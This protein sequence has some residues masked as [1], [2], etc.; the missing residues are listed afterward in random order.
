MDGA[1]EDRAAARRWA[2]L[3]LLAL[4]LLGLGMAL[5]G[6][7]GEA[8]GA[9]AALGTLAGAVGGFL[10]AG[11]VLRRAAVRLHR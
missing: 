8:S 3:G 6:A 7:L 1:H 4:V 2:W 11:A 5:G 9:G 10:G